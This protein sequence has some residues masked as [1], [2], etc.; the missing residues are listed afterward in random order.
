[1]A[2]DL[3]DG[4]SIGKAAVMLHKSLNPLIIVGSGANTDAVRLALMA[5]WEATE[6]PFVVMAQAKGAMDEFSRDY[7]GSV[8][9][10]KND[11]IHCSLAYADLIINVGHSPDELPSMAGL[12]EGAKIIHFL[13]SASSVNDDEVNHSVLGNIA[14]NIKILTNIVKVSRDWRF[15]YFYNMKNK[16]T[17]GINERSS[18]N[19]SPVSACYAAFEMRERLGDSDVLVVDHALYEKCFIR[20][21]RS[22]QRNTLLVEKVKGGGL[23]LL[24]FS[25]L[26]FS[27]KKVA[28]ICD[29]EAFM[30]GRECFDIAKSLD[31]LIVVLVLGP[32]NS[33]IDN[34][35]LVEEVNKL[36]VQ[37]YTPKDGEGFKRDTYK[38]KCGDGMQVVIADTDKA[39]YLDMEK[40]LVGT[41][42]DCAED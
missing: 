14:A 21:Y 27:D 33:S 9:Y 16:Q 11:Y 35:S 10:E 26:L 5:F 22:Y 2:V 34:S 36:G 38:A 23:A 15:S 25:S 4:D 13:Q 42:C 32:D 31:L 1:M 39:A 3:A 18:D 30:A 29:E 6:I 7:L 19:S 20:E 37:Y 12:K 17:L 28:L 24:I 41:P 40:A 8:A